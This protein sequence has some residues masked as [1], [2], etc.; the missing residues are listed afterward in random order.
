MP[1]IIVSPDQI[2]IANS[3]GLSVPPTGSDSDRLSVWA[4]AYFRYRITTAPRSQKEQAR[5]IAHLLSFLVSSMGNDQRLSWTPR[6]SKALVDALRAQIRPDGKRR[7]SDRTVNRLIASLKTFARWVHEL[8]PFALGDPMKGV[9]TIALPSPLEIE[10]ALTPQERSRILDAADGLESAGRSK[11]RRRHKGSSERPLRAGYRPLRNRAMVYLLTETG[12][13]RAAVVALNLV[14]I[15]FER[16]SVTVEEKGG[17][18]HRYKV[19]REGMQALRDY[20]ER[21]RGEDAIT[22]P[23]CAAF[24]LASSTVRNSNGRL[25][26]LVV[27]QVWATVCAIAGVVGKTPHSARHAMGKHLM[28]TTGNVAAVQRQ[29]GHRN[30]SYSLQYA[31]ITERELDEALNKPRK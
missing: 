27:N 5:D 13:R 20:L 6:A 26:P 17:V 7:F 2:A 9:R 21:E 3:S 19:S 4:A 24:F 10:R 16:S 18:R 25:T 31:R 8:A 11:S 14:D 12:M 1:S 30:A 28:D 15:D 22:Y 23:E 29:L